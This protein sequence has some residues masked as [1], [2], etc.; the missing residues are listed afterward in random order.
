[1]RLSKNALTLVLSILMIIGSIFPALAAEPEMQDKVNTE[2][3]NAKVLL[4]E[5]ALSETVKELLTKAIDELEVAIAEEPVNEA[6]VAEKE[7]ALM[8]ATEVAKAQLAL[9]AD[10]TKAKEVLA[11]EKLVA[12]HKM[13]LDTAIKAAEAIEKGAE[14]EVAKYEAAQA[15]LAKAVEVAKKAIADKEEADKAAEEIKKQI[16]SL[17][18]AIKE[19]AEKAAK[20]NKAEVQDLERL[21]LKQR[22]QLRRLQKENKGLK[23]LDSEVED[24]KKALDEIKN[25]NKGGKNS[26]LKA[27]RDNNFTLFTIG[28]PYYQRVIDGEATTKQMDVVPMIENNRTLLPLRFVAEALNFN[29]RW[30][31]Y[32]G[33]AEFTNIANPTFPGRT[34]SYNVKTN[35]VYVDGVPTTVE[36]GFRIENDRIFAGL[37][38][39]TLLFGGTAGDKTDG[40]DNTVEWSQ[41]DKA[42]FVYTLG[43]PLAEEHFIEEIDTIEVTDIKQGRPV[44]TSALYDEFN[45]MTIEAKVK[46]NKDTDAKFYLV[47]GDKIVKGYRGAELVETV[48]G[49]EGTIKFE[50]PNREINNRDRFDIVAVVGEKQKRFDGIKFKTEIPE[51]N[52]YVTTKGH[53]YFL[54]IKA[55]MDIDKD[56]YYDAMVLYGDKRYRAGFDKDGN[57]VHE[58]IRVIEDEKYLYVRVADDFNNVKE[59]KFTVPV[60]GAEDKRIEVEKPAVGRD[61]LYIKT[62]GKDV[63]V[64]IEVYEKATDYDIALMRNVRLNDEGW[65]MVSLFDYFNE[66]LKLD[67]GMV[68]KIRV[69][70]ADNYS[71]IYE[72]K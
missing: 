69:A 72:V 27:A 55:F 17:K 59:F 44:R 71:Y 4:E 34:V 47:K 39:I 5:G 23:G 31:G 70:G 16:E 18:N 46:K 21:L 45:A 66:N 10:I 49:T 52:G 53:G 28:N 48:N 54:D 1:M 29:V 64:D 61:Y 41:A 3:A 30:D 58:D 60:A 57:I 62:F 8:S 19:E 33:V 7:A 26:A 14:A 67:E 13:E 25:P 65:T 42:I 56:E 50:I 15:E 24:I 12:G 6:T 37:R 68:I 9:S 22:E 35:T 32:N 63:R 38:D 51:L 20:A 36:T 40:V 2:V 43:G 11:N